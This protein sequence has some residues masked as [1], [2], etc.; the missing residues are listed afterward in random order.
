MSRRIRAVLLDFYGTV[1][2]GDRDAVLRVC[3]WVVDAL[4][5]PM[6]PE[7]FATAWGEF[8]FQEIERCNQGRF[9]T[10]HECELASLEAMF[11]SLGVNADPQ[12][13]VAELEAYWADPP[14]YSDAIEF[15]QHVDVPVCCVSNA[16]TKPLLTA[17]ENS[18]LAP[19]FH[20]VVSSEMASSYKPDER[21]FQ[22]ALAGLETRDSDVIHVGDSL[23]SDIA[24]ANAMGITSVWINRVERIHDI[25]TAD[26]DHTVT[27]LTDVL[28]LLA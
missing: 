19:S 4:D 13:F 12:P 22:S 2:S 23:H 1:C 6:S 21:I 24:G 20:S 28:S 27:T 26:P 18:G 25:G 15:L 5:I 10:L 16:D 3:T 8:F 14:I 9:Q 7:K 17:M 11:L